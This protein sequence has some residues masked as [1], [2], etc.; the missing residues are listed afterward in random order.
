M[1]SYFSSVITDSL[2]GAGFNGI[3]KSTKIIQITYVLELPNF[4]KPPDE[5]PRMP[6][7]TQTP[8]SRWGQLWRN[9][10]EYRS[11]ETRRARADPLFK[12]DMS[13]NAPPQSVE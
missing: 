5:P 10:R 7:G 8:Q 1:I 2:S 13:R 9:F 4:A 3:C 6:R 11:P 12:A